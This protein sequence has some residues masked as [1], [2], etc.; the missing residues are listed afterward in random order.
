M[1]SARA[2][3]LDIAI[4]ACGIGAGGAFTPA[5]G[6][7][8]VIVLALQLL[9]L[10]IALS[11]RAAPILV[12]LRLAGGRKIDCLCAHAHRRG[13]HAH[14]SLGEAAGEREREKRT[15]EQ[16]DVAQDQYPFARRGRFYLTQPCLTMTW[17]D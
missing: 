16:K 5:A 1:L 6:I 17:G 14:G 7:H 8:P 9:D 15:Q 10:A 2:Q 13:D 4:D 3:V 12:G 11:H